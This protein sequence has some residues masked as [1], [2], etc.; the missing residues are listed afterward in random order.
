MGDRA[1][2]R[3][4]RRLLVTP[5]DF[6]IHPNTAWLPYDDI[7]PVEVVEAYWQHLAICQLRATFGPRL[8]HELVDR[9]GAEPR[10]LRRRLSGEYRMNLGDIVRWA[11]VFN[12]IA[13]IPPFDSA[14]DLLP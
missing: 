6:G 11:L 4:P 9:T 1:P 10:Y 8:E 2:R 13:L 12:D 14:N 7:D 5:A 3:Q